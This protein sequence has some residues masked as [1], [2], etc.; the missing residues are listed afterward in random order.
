MERFTKHY[1]RFSSQAIAKICPDMLLVFQGFLFCFV[2]WAFVWLV[3][4][5]FVFP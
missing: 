4:F 1:G 3:W 5:C 2:V